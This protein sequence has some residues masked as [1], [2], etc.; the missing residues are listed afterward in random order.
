MTEIIERSGRKLIVLVGKLLHEIV[1]EKNIEESQM[2]LGQSTSAT[3]NSPIASL[4][5]QQA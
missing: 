5:R 3:H 4:P 1:P 2:F